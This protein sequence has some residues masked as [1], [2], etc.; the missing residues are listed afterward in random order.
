MNS[1][2]NSKK[3]LLIGLIGAIITVIGGELPLGW[4]TNPELVNNILT[5]Q[6]NGIL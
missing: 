5:K 4:Y 3:L 6:V 2:T 1:D